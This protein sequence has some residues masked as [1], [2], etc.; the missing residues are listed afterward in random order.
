MWNKKCFL[1]LIPSF[2]GTLIFFIIPYFRVLYYSFID[3]QFTRNFIGFDNYIEILKNEYFLLALKNSLLI[4]IIAVPILILLALLISSVLSL[5][6]KKLRF[7]R[8]AF[9]LPIVIPTA[10]VVL[11]WQAFFG[12]INNV[13]PVYLLFIWKNIG[14]CV[15]LF[16]AAFSTIEDSIFE[17][18]KLDGTGKFNLHKKI[19]IPMIAPTILFSTLLSIVNSFKIF[20]E[21]YLYYGGTNYPPDY[22]YTL[23]YYMNNNF[24]KLNYQSLAT[25]AVLTSIL[26][27]VIVMGGLWLQRRYQQ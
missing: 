17:A 9:I 10:S 22:S 11:F 19:T 8:S 16:T 26:V 14:I 20:K 1:C 7:T 2:I 4:I 21:S 15:I 6:I 18:A 27:F 13:M 12:G 23:Q 5:G 25:S 24:V 3:N